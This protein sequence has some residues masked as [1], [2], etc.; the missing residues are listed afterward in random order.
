MKL[1][2]MQVDAQDV[3][4]QN[5]IDRKEV[6]LGVHHDDEARIFFADKILGDVELGIPGWNPGHL[7]ERSPD[8]G[9]VVV[10]MH[11]HRQ[12]GATP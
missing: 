8:A 2:E 3:A 7:Q 5:V 11:S 1:V 9:V 12:S 4:D 10:V 6:G